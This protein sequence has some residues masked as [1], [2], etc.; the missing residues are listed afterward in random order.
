MVPP[1][2]YN[3]PSGFCERVSHESDF[4]KT[5]AQPDILEGAT[6]VKMFGTEYA[7]IENYKSLIEYTE[8]LVKVQGKHMRVVIEGEKLGIESFQPD[9]CRVCGKIEKIYFAS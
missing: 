6:I 4:R 1:P 5:G 2:A 3:I 8:C 9:E 7:I